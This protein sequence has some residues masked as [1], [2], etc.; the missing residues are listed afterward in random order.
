MA[1]PVCEGDGTCH[2]YSS[3]I[4]SNKQEKDA[5]HS[6]QRLDHYDWAF[7]VH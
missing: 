5:V 1:L 7:I 4:K 3:V 2:L 6:L